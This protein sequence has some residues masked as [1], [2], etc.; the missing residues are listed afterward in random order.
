MSDKL[1]PGEVN[2]LK[3][4]PNKANK[5]GAPPGYDNSRG[6]LERAMNA[7][8]MGGEP[9]PG[10]QVSRAGKGTMGTTIHGD[11]RVETWQSQAITGSSADVATGVPVFKNIVSP[12]GDQRQTI[13]D[14]TME[15]RVT[16]QNGME[17]T[18][19][20]ALEAGFVS[21]NPDGS[22]S[23]GPEAGGG[24]TQGDDDDDDD[25][26]EPH[27]DLVA[28]FL[29]DEEAEAIM[30]ELVQ[31]T[32]VGDQIEIIGQLTSGEGVVDQHL[33]DKAAG[34][35]RLEP[36]ALTS[37]METVRA[38][39]LVQASAVV[40]KHGVDP[41]AV[42]LWSNEHH[43]PELQKA[44]RRHA[45]HGTPAVYNAIAEAYILALPEHDPE[46]ILN[47]DFGGQGS[48]RRDPD[49]GKIVITDSN[50]AQYDWAA[51]VRSGIVKLG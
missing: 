2:R 7:G 29:P 10:V 33:L 51:A 44:T 28:E 3:I 30:T 15:S 36:D 21:Q 22:Y 16:L 11:G 24:G 35:A 19:R 4:D 23:E 31:N 49:T 45:I 48:A 5:S 20:S 40:A 13:N 27:P 32:S 46:L 34:D 6:V 39:M 25:D 38:S 1:H 50:G 26:K 14:A 12:T 17:M 9:E 8:T 47:S 37:K 42:W 43:L 41:E 18:I